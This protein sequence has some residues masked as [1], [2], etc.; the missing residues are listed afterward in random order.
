VPRQKRIDA[1][2]LP[3]QAERFAMAA[4]GLDYLTTKGYVPVGFD[5]FALPSDPLV[6]AA[7]S[8]KLHRNFQGFTDDTAPVLIGLG[9]TAIS[10]FPQAIVQNEK[11]AGRYQMMI[12]QDHLPGA[13]G[14]LR[15]QDDRARGAVIENLL[16]H[17]HALVPPD[18]LAG[19]TG[20]MTPFI[21]RGLAQISDSVVT[22][23]P[24]GLPYTRTIAALFDGYRQDSV[25]RF[26]SA[27]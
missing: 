2:H 21:T 5:H 13:L 7:R 16:C 23:A 15:S 22:I 27:V 4:F 6:Q 1:T 18:L 25:R 9:A 26:S 12:S 20:A 8:G 11:N 14:V 10:C 3:D 17:G 24:E 19:V